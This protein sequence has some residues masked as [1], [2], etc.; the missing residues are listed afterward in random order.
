MKKKKLRSLYKKE[1]AKYPYIIHAT[2]KAPL[3]PSHTH[4]MTKLGFP[5]FLMDPLSFGSN[6]TGSRISVSYEYF[7]KPENK[8]KLEAIKNG[9]TVK[10]TVLDLAPN[11][12]GIDPSVYCYRRVYPEFEMVKMAYL[13]ESPGDIDPKM[14]FVQIY[15][16]GDDYVLTDAYYKGG[17]KW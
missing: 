3:Y 5:E 13:V 6:G 16:E 10:L 15:V 1:D 8:G 2:D 4:G 9:E 12:A 17:I 7:N 14:W 11:K